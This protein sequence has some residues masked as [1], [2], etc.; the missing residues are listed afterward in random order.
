MNDEW[1][2]MNSTLLHRNKQIR[3]VP[4]RNRPSRFP[5][6][7]RTRR[8]EKDK[9]HPFHSP[10]DGTVSHPNDECWMMNDERT[11]EGSAVSR[12]A[13]ESFTLD[14]APLQ[15]R[16]CTSSIPKQVIRCF[17]CH[18]ARSHSPALQRQ[19]LNLTFEIK[20]QHF[21]WNRSIPPTKRFGKSKAVVPR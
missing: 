3:T 21:L 2:L 20:L 10:T 11:W 9:T 7:Q 5:P 1:R 6:E 18:D 4:H 16:W 12:W 17:W 15:I 13:S 14:I 8:I 19:N